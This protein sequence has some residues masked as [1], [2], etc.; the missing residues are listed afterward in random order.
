MLITK[1]SILAQE[2]EIKTFEAKV[3]RIIE[4]K[5]IEIEGQKQLYQKI[6]LEIIKGDEKETK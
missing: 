3:V 6:E 2:N 1:T 4:E 5:E